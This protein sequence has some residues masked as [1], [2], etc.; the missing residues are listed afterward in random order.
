M[1]DLSPSC[2]DQPCIAAQDGLP[3]SA[4]CGR[5]AAVTIVISRQS[6]DKSRQQRVPFLGAIGQKTC[7]FP[8]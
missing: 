5:L 3:M 7:H 2:T 6:L 8:K 1:H 4:P